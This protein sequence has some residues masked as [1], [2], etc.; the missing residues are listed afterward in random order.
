MEMSAVRVLHVIDHLDLGGAQTALLDM[1]RHRD[2][3]SFDVEVA[4]MHGPGHFAAELEKIGVAVHVLAGSKW[5]PAYVP[6]FLS[7]IRR[8]G[9]EILHFHLQGA[10]WL[11]KPLAALSTAA[12]RVAHDHSSG[13][14]R[15]RGAGSLMPDALGHLFSSRIIAVSGGVR[16]FLTRW[17]AVPDDAVEVISNGVNVEEFKPAGARK[18]LAARERWG[19]APDAFVAGAIGRLAFEKNFVMLPALAQRHPGLTVALAGN[20][21]E[22]KKIEAAAAA[23][24]VSGRMRILGSIGDRAAFYNM[25]DVFLLPSLYEGLPMVLLEAMAAGVPVLCSRLDGIAGAL[26]EESEGLLAEP[27]NV[28]EF[29]RQLERLEASVELRERL[30]TAARARVESAFSAAMTMR[31]VEAL[32]RRELAIANAGRA[33]KCSG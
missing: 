8:G 11:A 19:V 25:L 30:A 33:A 31:R 27:G 9:F 4:V 32:Y 16:D 15:F 12:V 28:E 3:S 1:L 14:L 26:K 13:D 18:R 22:Q 29:S 5:P 20:G 21:P 7:L 23:C 17:E 10:N 6:R 24:D 2:R